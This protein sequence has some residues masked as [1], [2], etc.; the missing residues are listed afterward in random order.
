MTLAN[1]RR[2]R[3]HPA[4]LVSYRAKRL[5]DGYMRWLLS[6]GTNIPEASWP[7]EMIQLKRAA[8]LARRVQW[9]LKRRQIKETNGN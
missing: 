2:P 5:T 1:F 7:E 9:R 6:K 3:R 8:L 4:K